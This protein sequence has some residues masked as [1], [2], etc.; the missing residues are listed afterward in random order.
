MW[1]V[2]TWGSFLTS[3]LGSPA[4]SWILTVPLLPAVSWWAAA[5][6]AVGP[7]SAIATRVSTASQA[8]ARVAP[9]RGRFPAKCVMS[10]TSCKPHFETRKR[11]KA[12]AGTGTV[13]CVA[14]EVP[15][16]RS[17]YGGTSRWGNVSASSHGGTTPRE[18]CLA[19]PRGQKENR[20]AL[21]HPGL[22]FARGQRA[23]PAG[24][25]PAGRQH[26]D[27][28][29][30]RGH[31][32]EHQPPALG[33]RH[34]RA[35]EGVSRRSRDARPG[36]ARVA[37]DATTG[38]V[39]D[40]N[41]GRS[42]REFLGRFVAA[43]RATRVVEA[44]LAVGIDG[45]E[46]RIRAAEAVGDDDLD[47]PVLALG[48]PVVLKDAVRSRIG[49]ADER[50]LGRAEGLVTVVAVDREAGAVEQFIVGLVRGALR[51][52]LED[53]EASRRRRRRGRRRGRR[54]RRR[55]GRR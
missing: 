24:R 38:S 51:V 12:G 17:T 5:P 39:V 26:E 40:D 47:D 42:I 34:R 36:C 9:R 55:R 31:H 6:T 1:N 30:Q 19:A 41:N 2:Q 3:G 46:D 49:T 13:A 50:V 14:P 52:A 25:P 28:G 8:S 29:E 37:F 20:G 11:N 21:P 32:D 18:R 10:P 7:S 22:G 54:R 35:C 43:D 44:E 15:L 16:T 53:H 48:K 33:R 4:P 23:L 27:A 45:D